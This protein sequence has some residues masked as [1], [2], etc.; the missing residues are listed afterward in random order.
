MLVMLTY[1]VQAPSPS[2]RSTAAWWAW[3]KRSTCWLRESERRCGFVALSR[4]RVDL[5]ELQ[6]VSTSLLPGIVEAHRA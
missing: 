6:K 1:G 4:E 3:S 2:L 5:D